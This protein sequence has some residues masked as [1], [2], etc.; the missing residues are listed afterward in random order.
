M[1]NVFNNQKKNVI[2]RE[3]EFDFKFI[4]EFKFEFEFEFEFELIRLKNNTQ[5]KKI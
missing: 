1:I 3:F 5:I 2:K 4:F